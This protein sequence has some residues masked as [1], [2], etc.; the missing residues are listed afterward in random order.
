[1]NIEHFERA[2]ERTGDADQR[3]KLQRMIEEERAKADSAY[4]LADEA[5]SGASR[6][7]GG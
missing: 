6:R 2:L 7:M 3:A 4:P 1:M 5:P